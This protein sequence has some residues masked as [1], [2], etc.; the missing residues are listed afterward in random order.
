[1]ASL[2]FD[3]QRYAVEIRNLINS[4]C[5]L[6]DFGKS[7]VCLFLLKDTKPVERPDFIIDLMRNIT[8][9]VQTDCMRMP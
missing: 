8:V 7:V 2:I 3:I 6:H 5:R 1:M 9:L 4:E